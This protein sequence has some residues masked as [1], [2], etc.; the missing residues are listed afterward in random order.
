[1]IEE[2]TKL[3]EEEDIEQGN[4]KRVKDGEDLLKKSLNTTVLDCS[5]FGV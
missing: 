4:R 2:E 5:L 3:R 1:M